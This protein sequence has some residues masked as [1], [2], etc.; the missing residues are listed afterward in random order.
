MKK[1]AMF[2][3]LFICSSQLFSQQTEKSVTELK[4]EIAALES[5]VKDQSVEENSFPNQVSG[6]GKELGTALNGFVEALD[7]GMQVTTTR[8]NEFAQTD[9]GKYA[10]IAI[11]WKL[12]AQDILLVA[13]SAV[14]KAIGFSLLAV[15]CWLLKYTLET[16]CWGKMVVTKKEGPWYN[17]SVTK[18]RGHSMLKIE[19]EDEVGKGV[20]YTVT[21]IALFA[22][23]IS[24]MIG[25]S[26]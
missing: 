22:T 18:E 10:M 26:H 19:S 25:L 2:V 24:A 15:F 9:V 4:A 16:I 14:N 3:L 20:F 17:R 11:A 21:C 7:G 8:V 1:I 13:G 5:L 23:F 6:F 12:F